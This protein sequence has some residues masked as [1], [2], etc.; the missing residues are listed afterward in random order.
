[1]VDGQTALRSYGNCKILSSFLAR[2]LLTAR[3]EALPYTS[4]PRSCLPRPCSSPPRNKK[5]ACQWVAW[6]EIQGSQNFVPRTSEWRT[7][8]LKSLFS[9]AFLFVLRILASSNHQSYPSI[10]E[11]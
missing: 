8:S 7:A 9:F 10:V 5:I 4:P 1:M 11:P 6:A 3:S 2:S